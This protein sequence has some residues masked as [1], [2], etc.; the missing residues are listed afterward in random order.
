MGS[1]I[2]SKIFLESISFNIRK[3]DLLEPLR[4]MV[5]FGEFQVSYRRLIVNGF[6][7]SKIS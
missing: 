5:R 7:C 1:L 2:V 3:K 4:N 6:C